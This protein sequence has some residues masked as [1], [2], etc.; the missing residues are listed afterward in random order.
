MYENQI[1][2]HAENSTIAPRQGFLPAYVISKIP[3]FNSTPLP[4]GTPAS[5]TRTKVKYF[6]TSRFIVRFDV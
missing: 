2:R 3:F 6:Y 5:T 1:L 4:L